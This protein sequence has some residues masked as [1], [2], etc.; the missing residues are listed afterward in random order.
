MLELKIHVSQSMK[1]GA[2]DSKE[3]T[4]N[5]SRG[6]LFIRRGASRRRQTRHTFVW[7]RGRSAMGNC[8]QQISI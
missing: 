1:W 8:L 6:R 2:R 7:L 3:S 4:V 5:N